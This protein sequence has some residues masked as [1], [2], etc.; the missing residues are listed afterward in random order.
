MTLKIIL[1][2]CEEIIQTDNSI[3]IV[4]TIFEPKLTYEKLIKAT[5][6]ES[7]KRLHSINT[8]LQKPGSIRTDTATNI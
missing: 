6:K 7:K 5:I 8:Q 3:K 1:K 2:I 4:G